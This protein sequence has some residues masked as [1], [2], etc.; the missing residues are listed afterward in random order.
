MDIC[1]AYRNIEWVLCK[2]KYQ[3]KHDWQQHLKFSEL[4]GLRLAMRCD[5]VE[6][7]DLGAAG[8][9]RLSVIIIGC[10]IKWESLNT[11]VLSAMAE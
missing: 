11:L 8:V 1:V 9:K 4:N 2:F 7:K 10:I 3:P 5:G 6:C